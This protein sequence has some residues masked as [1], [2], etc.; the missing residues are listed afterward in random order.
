MEREIIL[1]E[2]FEHNMKMLET[3]F[4]SDHFFPG[5]PSEIPQYLEKN[6]DSDQERM[7]KEI[8]QLYMKTDE[9][10][11]FS[12]ISYLGRVKKSECCIPLFVHVL[13]NDNVT[14][15]LSVIKALEN[16][17]TPSCLKILVEHEEKDKNLNNYK[18]RVIDD[19]RP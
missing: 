15:R 12:V 13:E 14:L 17:G 1:I 2:E 3:L 10:I 4:G 16:L 7:K 11:K 18:L 6:F 9:E 8:I 19:L 5:L